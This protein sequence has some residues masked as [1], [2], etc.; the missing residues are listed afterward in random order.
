MALKKIDRTNN[1]RAVN[2]VLGAMT[3][4][5]WVHSGLDPIELLTVTRVPR[6]YRVVGELGSGVDNQLYDCGTLSDRLRTELKMR[7]LYRCVHDGRALH[8]NWW[9]LASRGNG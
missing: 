8:I 9:L 7:R 6:T 2:S 3:E 5:D 1:L 4:F